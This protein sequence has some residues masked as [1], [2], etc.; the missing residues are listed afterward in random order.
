VSEQPTH[1][2]MSADH[3]EK[4]VSHAEKLVEHAEKLITMAI[5]GASALIVEI[6]IV[7]VLLWRM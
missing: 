7:I 2:P 5:I 1:N 3:A 6:A 4:L